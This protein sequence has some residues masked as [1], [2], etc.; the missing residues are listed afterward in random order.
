[1]VGLGRPLVVD[2]N[3]PNKILS[4]N[5]TEAQLK[6]LATGIRALDR[7][8]MLRS[9]Y[10]NQIGRMGKGQK[11]ESPHENIW[12]SMEKIITRSES[13]SSDDAGRNC[14]FRHS[15]NNVAASK[16]NK[17]RFHMDISTLQIW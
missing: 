5:L 8:A 14:N 1:M 11:S 12:L 13:T 2:T 9:W 6:P 15:G 10:E 3:L 16:I 7:M 4:A 17:Q